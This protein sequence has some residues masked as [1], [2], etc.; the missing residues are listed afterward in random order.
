MSSEIRTYLNEKDIAEL[1]PAA[2]AADDY[3]LTHKATFG[4]SHD[5]KFVRP[6]FGQSHQHV[7]DKVSAG[8]TAR[9]MSATGRSESSP[10][11][12]KNDK[13]NKKFSGPKCFYC[14]RRG[15]VMSKC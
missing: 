5:K 11:P 10:S 14:H 9:S 15:H 6:P 12:N 1:G 13:S 7:S 3:F 8:S 4:K 2:V